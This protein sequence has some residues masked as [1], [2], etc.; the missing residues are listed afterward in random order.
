MNENLES[1][2]KNIKFLEKK[3]KKIPN[4]NKHGYLVSF[5]G[6]LLEVSGLNLSVGEICIIEVIY[7]KS[8]FLIEGEVIGFK[9]NN[10]FVMLFEDSKGISPG[11]RVFPKVDKHGNHKRKKF[12]VG[13]EL[14]GRTIDS[15]GNPLDELGSIDC[16]ELVSTSYEKINPLKRHPVTEILDTGI[17]AINFFLTVGKGQ[18]IG[19]FARTG[20]GKSVLLSMI[21]K[22][23]KFDVCVI[24]LIGERSREILE[25]IKNIKVAKNFNKSVV[26]VSPANTTPLLKIQGSLYSAKIAEYFRKKG[27]HVLFILDS[28]T[29]YAMAEREVA[30]SIGELPVVRGYPTSIF[31]KLPLFI[32]RSGNSNIKNGSITGLYTVLTENNESLDPIS[33]LAKSILDGHIVLSKNYA[34]S[35]HYP[36]IDVESSISRIMYDIVDKD[37]YKKSVYLKQLISEYMKNKDLIHLGAYVKGI[38]KNLDNAIELWPKIKKFLQQDRDV[39]HNFKD[40]YKYFVKILNK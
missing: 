1:W 5:V 25:F 36:A 30:L 29:R 24:G 26:I 10:I 23:S 20:V 40:S 22:Y 33:D 8:I 6:L 16:S 2:L 12:P 32:E 38:D 9:N 35:G 28:L 7:N 11:L 17:R 19:L 14:L 37:H 4:I 39:M 27:N 31:Y 18:R 21:S 13:Y 3:I 34:D 15:Y